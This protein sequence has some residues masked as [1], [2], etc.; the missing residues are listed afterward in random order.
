MPLDAICLDAVTGEVAQQIIGMKIDKI[1][2]PAGETLL[3]VLRGR[4]G[5]ARLLISAGS[6]DA[7]F[8]L[9]NARFES[10]AEPPMFCMLLRKHIGGAIVEGVVQ[11]PRE[12]MLELALRAFDITGTPTAKRLIVELMGRNSNI[13]LTG[14]DGV[15]IDCLRRVGGDLTDRRQVL[16]GMLYRLPP[17][18]GKRDPFDARAGEVSRG[19]AGVSGDMGADRW[20]L[21]TFSGFSP[22]ICREIVYRAYGETDVSVSRA[23]AGDAGR[24]LDIAFDSAVTAARERR[25]TP[26]LLR[27]TSGVP[28]DFSYTSITQYGG[29]FEITEPES[30]SALLDDFFT[31]RARGERL[32]RGA[33]DITKAARTAL[34]RAERKTALRRDELVR[35]RGRE[36]LRRR[37][38]I[39][40]A[41]IR[42]IRRGDTLLRTADIYSHEG[43]E[44][45]IELDPR[46]SPQQNAAAYYKEYTKKKNAEKYLSEQIL[47]G[48]T[49]IEYLG[50]V[51]EEIGRAVGSEDLEEI[52]A[53]LSD[54]GY[55]RARGGER[56]RGRAGKRVKSVPLSFV[57]ETGFE[58]LVGKN[59]TQND[60][61]THR[62]AARSDIWMHARGAPGSHVIIR[63]SGAEPD[64]TTL[65]QAAALA[66]WYSGARGARRAAVD[67]CRAGNVRRMPGGRPG[68]VT[69]T[70]FETIQASQERYVDGGQ[71]R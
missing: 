9:T 59:N 55:M 42:S 26:C 62:A 44:C 64:G 38:D 69:Y 8:H 58:I 46:K 2:Q 5:G 45:E 1:Q 61:L 66:A 51:L 70:N 57:S 21:E 17:G 68:M 13:I 7:R 12:R 30:F 35:A 36:D 47:A 48:E 24:S 56:A 19:L 22:L 50:S 43:A 20:L 33:A 65:A 27:E 53:E 16:P 15:I 29:A 40:M 3:L 31:E 41:N 32:R 23:L 39:I 10:P 71:L 25:F 11:P 52:R 67:Y 37:G 28:Y 63:T 54:A 34:G 49:E 6:G 14:E 60:E 18:Q 4:G